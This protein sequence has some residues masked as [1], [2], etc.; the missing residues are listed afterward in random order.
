[1]NRRASGFTLIELMV[2]VA[3]IGLLSSIAIPTFKN[4]Q[5]RSKQA[6]RAVMMKSIDTALA[7]YWVR[8]ARWP[9]DLGGGDSQLSTNWN[10]SWPP[11]A[12]KRKWNL[13]P[14]AG[15]WNRLSLEIQG[16]LYFSY[17]VYAYATRDYRYRYV[18]AYG[19]LD[20]DRQYNF[21]YRYVYDYGWT[22]PPQQYI[23]EYDSAEWDHTF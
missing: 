16:D 1:M 20:A 7:D 15:D 8:D 14:A 11:N 21:K 9:R 5:L 6:E 23:Y 12:Q 22:N 13:T 10:P 4:L 3:I 18:Y 2:V 17:Y 19:D